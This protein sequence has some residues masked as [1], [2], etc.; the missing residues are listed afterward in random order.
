MPISLNYIVKRAVLSVMIV[1]GVILLSYLLLILTPG[2]PASKWA[3]NPRGPDASRAIEL[4]R[5][6]LG[7]DQPLHLQV[8]NF[9]YSVFTGNLGLSIAFK[10]PVN[11]VILSGFTATLELIIFTYILA[12]PIGVWL[13]V[14]SALRR[15]GIIDDLIQSLSIVL[16]S[17]PTFWFGA[18]ILLVLHGITGGLPYGRVDTKLVINTGFKPITGFYLVDSLLTGNIPVFMDVLARLIPPA[19]AISIYPVGVLARITRTLVAETLL[20]DYIKAAVAWGIKRSTI[21]RDFIMRSIMPS[22][23]Q[24]AGLAFVYSLIDAMV[25][26]T[27]I[28]GREGLGRILLSSLYK[29]DFRVVIALVVYLT[30]FYIVVNTLVDVIQ[31]L[32]DP[33]VRL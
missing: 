13:G 16:T 15:G 12:I 19:L 8:L 27:V 2:D 32:I 14:L 26:E 20:E 23:I 5:R 31:A 28:F 18:M 7:L 9:L 3:G 6:E 11:Q 33:R 1:V 30:V 24:V 25:V 22:I 21:L 29:S 10:I 17:T 4:A